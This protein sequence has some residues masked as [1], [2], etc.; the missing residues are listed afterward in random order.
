MISA[1]A[2]DVL[3]AMFDAA[4]GTFP[5]VVVLRAATAVLHARDRKTPLEPTTKRVS[6]SATP[7]S[8]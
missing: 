7:T 3:A 2:I 5:T 8:P 4:V 6:R 1:G